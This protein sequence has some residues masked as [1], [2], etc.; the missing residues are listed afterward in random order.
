[1]TCSLHFR[2]SSV[3]VSSYISTEKQERETT[4]KV[5]EIPNGIDLKPT[6]ISAR[7]VSHAVIEPNYSCNRRCTLCYN[8]YRDIV[9]PFDQ[10]AAEVDQALTK[11]RL[12]TISILGGEPTLHAS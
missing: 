6:K 11:R 9:K 5:T 7:E 8:R 1:M 2:D 4:M 3:R 10:V 12:E